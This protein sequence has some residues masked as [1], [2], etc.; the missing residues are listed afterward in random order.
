M[1]VQTEIVSPAVKSP[2]SEKR[3][4][5]LFVVFS[6]IH[7]LFVAYPLFHGV[8]SGSASLLKVAFHVSAYASYSLLYLFPAVLCIL[9]LRKIF[10]AKRTL[11]A[12]AAV[13]LTT[14]SLVVIQVDR[15]IF[16]LFNFHINGFVLN[17]V[18]TPGGI[19][20]LGA[21]SASHLGAILLVL[22]LLFVQTAFFASSRWFGKRI[23]VK[24]ALVRA[25]VA[26]GLVVAVTGQ[27]IYG[28]SDLMAISE[29]TD[30]ANVYPFAPQFTFRK[31]AK[32]LGIQAERGKHMVTKMESSEL[33][34][35]L[36]PI[37]YREIKNPPNIVWLVAESLRADRLSPEIMP[38]S[39][40]FSERAYRFNHHYSAGNGTRE[41]MFGMFYGL[42]GS[43]WFMFLH[44]QRG[45]L[46]IDRVMDLGYQLHFRT[47]ARFSYPEFDQ[48]LF[49]NVPSSA[50]HE[51]EFSGEA[52]ERDENNTTALIDF[53]R[54]RDRHRPFMS[55]M[56]F[57]STHASYSYPD[58]G[59][60]FGPVMEKVDYTQMSREMLA[61][62][63]GQLLNRYANGAHWVDVQ[64][65]RVLDALRQEGVLNNTIVVITGD[66][67]EEFMEH[68]HWGHN[69]SFNDSQI[70]VPL[71]V[72]I[73]G[74]KPGMTDHPTS[75][76]DI[77]VT[78]MQQL[79]AVNNPEN[80]ALGRN[81]FMEDPRDYI[82]LS[83][84]NSIEIVAP[85][86][87][88]RS[89]YRYS[90]GVVPEQPT[91]AHDRP[92]DDDQGRKFLA[93]KQGMIMHAIEDVS[94]FT[95]AGQKV[96]ARHNN[97]RHG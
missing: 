67:G 18:L 94:R 56:F 84:W 21:D 85:D 3:N 71:V 55:F 20:S 79:G 75:H 83:D 69:S 51:R 13:L 25:A 29:V 74:R 47:S 46:L 39:W 91:D 64:A 12:V 36:N 59:N 68:G 61:D 88:Y 22:R 57:E 87:K 2:S 9:I 43:N 10:S 53:I 6:W 86:F 33:L 11:M 72:S 63:A 81:L 73:P 17:L 50:L 58:T 92:F 80:Y 32:K 31:L 41:A 49:A 90:G 89:P 62:H 78:L 48:T 52:W 77:A 24:P 30:T 27:A 19:E 23:S 76:M 96:L 16:D 15:M 70:R 95:R 34:Y 14:T 5:A 38:N 45:P 8:L 97:H 35:P 40:A 37:A 4:L 66:H 7:M 1:E 54:K 42:N 44:A 26:M 65:G 28:F 93:E 60:I 82:L